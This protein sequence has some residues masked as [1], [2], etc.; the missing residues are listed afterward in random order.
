[1]QM[2]AQTLFEGEIVGNTGWNRTSCIG[3]RFA[4]VSVGFLVRSGIFD[5]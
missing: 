1:M 2:P 3:F 5:E 4:F